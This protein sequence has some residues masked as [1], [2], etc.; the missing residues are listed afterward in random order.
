MSKDYDE[1]IKKLEDFKYRLDD[2]GDANRPEF[3]ASERKI[4]DDLKKDKDS[5]QGKLINKVFREGVVFAI[6]TIYWELD[7]IINGEDCDE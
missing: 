4:I 3:T 6:E 5:E 2:W 7:K 1:L